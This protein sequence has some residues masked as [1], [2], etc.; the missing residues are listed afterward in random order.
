MKPK[1]KLEMLES[2]P[3]PLPSDRTW[4]LFSWDASIAEDFP[5]CGETRTWK[6]ILKDDLGVSGQSKGRTGGLGKI[7]VPD[8]FEVWVCL[9]KPQ[10]IA[11]LT[12][13][14]DRNYLVNATSISTW[15]D[16]MCYVY[17][18]KM[19][20]FVPWTSESVLVIFNFLREQGR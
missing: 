6:E 11:R 7:M 9:K 3:V 18:E 5:E 14:F 19:K 1:L 15:Q 13:D 8:Q 2:W 10:C 12:A 16:F 20:R 17:D 4:G